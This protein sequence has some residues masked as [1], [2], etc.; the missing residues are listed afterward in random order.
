MALY[1]VLVNSFCYVFL[2]NIFFVAICLFVLCALTPPVR[3][4]SFN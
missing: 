2:V 3:G 4:L 1:V